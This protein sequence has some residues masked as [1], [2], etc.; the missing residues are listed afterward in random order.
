MIT[1]LVYL[2][3]IGFILGLLYWL[4]DWLGTPQPINKVLKAVILLV[5]VLMLVNFLLQLAGQPS[6]IKWK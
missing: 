5:G 6:F 2:I 1:A 3:I 4:V